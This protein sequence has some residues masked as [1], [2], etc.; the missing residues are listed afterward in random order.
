MARAIHTPRPLR[1][2]RRERGAA[3]VVAMVALALLSALAVDLAYESR[4]RLQIAANGRDE[5]R[6]SKI[7]AERA[8]GNDKI[9]F[10][11]NSEVAEIHG[12]GKLT[13][14]TLRDTQ[15][16][17]TRALAVT[18]AAAQGVT[19]DEARWK[20]VDFA[21]AEFEKA[22]VSPNVR[23]IT[24]G[25]ALSTKDLYALFPKAPARTVARIAGIPKPAGCI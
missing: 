24:Q 15:T 1:P 7:M 8:F 11:W 22:G 17:K 18:I 4:V 23:R 13:G 3:L 21:R 19:L 5:L 2:A 10:A 6:A 14:V 9:R 16:G 25:A 20:V 12:E